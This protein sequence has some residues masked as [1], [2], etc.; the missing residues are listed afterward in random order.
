MVSV[1]IIVLVV[2]G[3]LLLLFLLSKKKNV[4]YNNIFL[5]F[6]YFVM[7]KAKWGINAMDKIAKKSPRFWHFMANVSIFIGFF[8]MIFIVIFLGIQIYEYLFNNGLPP[9]QPLLPGVTSAPG[10][11]TLSAIHWIIAIFILAL[12]HEFAH[13]LF[14]RV[15]DIKVKSS[16]FAF[17][18]IVLPIIPAAFVEPDEKQMSKSSRKKQYAVLSAGPFANVITFLVFLGV[19]F[20]MAPVA[21]SITEL[22]GVH[23]ISVEENSPAFLAGLQENETVQSINNKEINNIEEFQEVLAGTKPYQKIDLI[24]DKGSY[25]ITTAENPSN[26]E[27]SYIGVGIIPLERNLNQDLVNKYGE[28]PLRGFLWLSLLVFWIWVTNL[29]VGL[30][31]L[32]PVGPLDGGK[33]FYLFL[34]SKIKNEKV[35]KKIWVWFS[36]IIG[37]IITI[38]LLQQFI[39]IFLGFF[40]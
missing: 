25:S 3:L 16:G 24:T 2:F 28:F 38:L 8:G 33:M 4:K 29:G 12:V 23:I 5:Y 39:E 17:L 14:A 40:R 13:G 7:Y 37:G 19:F 18:G 35:A 21:S 1:D 34:T 30:V 27:A 22:Q 32:L 20:L 9:I 36:I 11:P 26:S 10:L 15:Y 6:I 31:N